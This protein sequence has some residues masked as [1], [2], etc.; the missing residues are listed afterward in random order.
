MT[1]LFRMPFRFLLFLHLFLFLPFLSSGSTVH[2]T[3]RVDLLTADGFAVLAGSAVTGNG[4]CTVTGN[5][6]L[7]PTGG[8]AITELTCA[9]VTGTIYD[10]NAGYTGGGGGSTACLVT[11]AGLL[12]TAKNDLTTASNDAVGRTT[13]STV[14]TELG[15]STLTDGVY[16]SAAGTFGITGTLTLDGGGNVDSVFIFKMATTLITASSSQVVLTNSA[17]ACNVYWIVGSSATIGTSSTFVG[18]ILAAD[19]IT[20]NGGSTINGRLLAKGAAVT[21]NNTT[22]TKQTCVE[23]F[24]NS[25]CDDADSCTTDTCSGGTCSNTNTPVDGVWTYNPWGA[26]S[27]SCGGGSGTRTRTTLS[28]SATCGGSCGTAVTSES[29]TNTDV[30]PTSTPTPTPTPTTSTSTTTTSSTSTST[31]TSTSVSSDTSCPPFKDGII[32]PQIIGSRRIDADSIYLSWGPDSGTDHF[33]IR[34]GLTS[35]VYSF[36]TD[37]TGFSTTINGLP[38]NTPIWV[39]VAARNDCLIG[40]YGDQK[41]LGGTVRTGVPGLPDTGGT[42]ASGS[43]VPRFPSTGFGPRGKIDLWYAATILL[44]GL[45]FFVSVKI[46]H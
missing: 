36:N 40:S 37:I 18:N 16:D 13:T 21:L 7:S 29:C 22:V 28:C 8:T 9:E 25:D 34:Y 6:G 24:T 5:V 45:H 10:T 33:N 20:D 1:I 41:L 14:A 43:G 35:G 4:T 44:V 2:A 3:T 19:S 12:T 46:R 38:S 27:G 39:Q 32:T 15:G 42:K 31:S 17:Q 26:C 11:D 23:C 30:C